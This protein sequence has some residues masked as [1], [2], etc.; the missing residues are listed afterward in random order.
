MSRENVIR[1]IVQRELEGGKLGRRG[2]RP[3]RARVTPGG[4]ENLAPC[5]HQ[6]T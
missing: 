5:H 4:I 2:G 6:V 3:G 1:G